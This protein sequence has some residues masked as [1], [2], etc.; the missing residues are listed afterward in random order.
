VCAVTMKSSGCEVTAVYLIKEN[1]CSFRWAI[2]H[3]SNNADGTGHS[4]TK[5]PRN[6]LL[7][8]KR[9]TIPTVTSFQ[10]VPGDLLDTLRCF[11]SPQ[12]PIRGRPVT[13]GNRLLKISALMSIF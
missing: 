6:S 5:L 9:V 13:H 4:S 3:R 7:A 10:G 1:S 2:G 8:R 12:H 11:M